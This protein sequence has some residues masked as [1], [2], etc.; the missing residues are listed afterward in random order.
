M[1]IISMLICEDIRKVNI[2]WWNTKTE[3]L[4]DSGHNAHGV[5][6]VGRVRHLHADL[7]QRRAH[8]A[9]GERDHVHRAT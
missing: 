3:I 4:T 1:H 8:G 2:S 7:G 9:H 5:D 6:D